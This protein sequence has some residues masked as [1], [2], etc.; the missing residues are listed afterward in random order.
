MKEDNFETIAD[1]KEE[2]DLFEELGIS[3]WDSYDE[4]SEFKNK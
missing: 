1:E 2:E 4:M 3:C